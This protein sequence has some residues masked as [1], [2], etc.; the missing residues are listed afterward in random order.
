MGRQSEREAGEDS[1]IVKHPP[2]LD[3]WLVVTLNDLRGEVLECHGCREGA[4]HG[5][6]VRAERVGLMSGTLSICAEIQNVP[7]CPLVP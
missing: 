4:P 1:I 5:I 3:L 6:E 7:Y 2:C